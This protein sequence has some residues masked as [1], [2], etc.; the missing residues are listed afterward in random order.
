MTEQELISRLQTLKQIKPN[1]NW[2]FSVKSRILR[3]NVF[4]ELFRIPS[5]MKMAYAFS[6]LLLIFVGAFGVAKFVGQPADTTLLQQTNPAAILGETSIKTSIE[7]F[8]TKSQNLA[9]A[10]KNSTS[11]SKQAAVKELTDAAK[12]LA[13][14]IEKDPA[15]AKTVALELKQD[16]TLAALADSNADT[17]VT[18]D[19]VYK[20]LVEQLF[21]DEA[22]T[23][24]TEA[25]QKIDAKA[26]VLYDSGK[27]GEA[28]IVLINN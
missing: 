11:T 24:P 20:P 2:A 19:I 15:V 5:Q 1:D 4:L 8:K 17:K 27:F 9:V 28:L 26:K 21:K 14:V 3:K 7:A 6:A 22:N 12:R 13:A 18:S 10:V 25:R 23:T 16:G